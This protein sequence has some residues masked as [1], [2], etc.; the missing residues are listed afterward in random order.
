MLDDDESQSISFQEICIQIKK[1]VC[2]KMP[3]QG[4]VVGAVAAAAAEILLDQA[5]LEHYF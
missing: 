4:Y 1:L 2:S 5:C 3:V